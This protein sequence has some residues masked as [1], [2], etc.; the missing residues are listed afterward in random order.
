MSL[1]KCQNFLNI[2]SRIMETRMSMLNAKSRIRDWNQDPIIFPKVIEGKIN[3]K[4]FLDASQQLIRLIG[5][6][7]FYKKVIRVNS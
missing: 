5:K 1:N 3:T 6:F 2:S 7:K 4:Q